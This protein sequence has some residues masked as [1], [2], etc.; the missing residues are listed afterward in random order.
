MEKQITK[1]YLE[2]F[3]A[4]EDAVSSLEKIKQALICAQLRAEELYIS[5]EEPNE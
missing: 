1:E 3:R 2:L 5:E 4:V